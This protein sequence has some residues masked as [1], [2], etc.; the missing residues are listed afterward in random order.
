MNDK[1]EWL[2]KQLP[3]EQPKEKEQ[4]EEKKEVFIG[5]DY[6]RCYLPEPDVQAEVLKF[7]NLEKKEQQIAEKQETVEE[8][9]ELAVEELKPRIEVKLDVERIYRSKIA[10]IK[11]LEKQER[12]LKNKL[13]RDDK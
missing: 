8:F 7:L 2:K 11:E 5:E 3:K 1:L 6:F 13:K 10:N 12:A 4:K 9:I